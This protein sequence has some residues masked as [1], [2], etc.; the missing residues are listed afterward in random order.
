MFYIFPFLFFYE[1]IIGNKKHNLL[2][3]YSVTN[4]IYLLYLTFANN[5]LVKF[6]FRDYSY[7]N[8][9][10]KVSTMMEFLGKTI[11]QI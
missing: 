8:F 7:F 1:L 4:I 5:L 2:L 10:F 9:Y 11:Y 6:K 3:L